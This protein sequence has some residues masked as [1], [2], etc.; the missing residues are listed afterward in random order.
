MSHDALVVQS[1]VPRWGAYERVTGAAKYTADIKPTGMLIGK[2]LTS[3]YPHARI[4]KVDKSK[5]EA[6]PGVEG[7]IA[8]EDIPKKT[9]IPSKH[10]LTL[11]PHYHPEEEIRDMYVLTDKARFVGDKI[12]AVAAVDEATA[13]KALELIEVEYEVLEAVFDPMEAMRPGSPV[14][15]DFAKNNIPLRMHFPGSQ[16]DVE[17]GFQEADC[18]IED[19]FHSSKQQISQMEPSACVASFG[20]DGRLTIWSPNQSV[21]LHRTKIAELFDMPEGM[22]R[23]ITPH[24]GGSFGKHGSLH[25]EPVCIALAKKTGKPVKVEYSREEDFFGTETRQTFITQAKIG[26]KK[27]GAIVALEEKLISDG[28]AYFSRSRVTSLVNIGAFTG[29]YRCAN[30]SADLECVYTNTPTT[31]GIRGYGNSEATSV[32]EQ[33]VDRAAAEIG[34]DP[35]ELRLKNVK[36]AGDLSNSGLPMRACSLEELIRLGAEKVGWREKRARDKQNGCKR[37]GIGMAIM[38]DVSGAY[39]SNIQSRNAYL[40]FNEDGSINLMVSAYDM[41]QN[42][43]GT[44][45]QIAAEA[46]GIRYEDVHMV[47]GDTDTTMFD[48]GVQA[49]AGLYQMG[50]AVLDA[51]QQAKKRLLERAAKKMGSVAEELDIR[52][53]R[54]YLK[55]N[56]SIGIS[57]GEVT[58]Q[59]TYNFEGDNEN[60]SAKGTFSPSDNPPPFAAVFAE[61]EVDTQTG[62]VEVMKILYVNDSGTPINP[63]TVEGQIEGGVGQAIGYTLTESYVVNRKTGRLETDN[64][65]T[66]MIPSALDMPEIEMVLYQDPVASGPFGAKA[67]GHSTTIAVNPAI[68][69]A[70]YDA[71]GVSITDMPATAEKILEA[72]NVR[73]PASAEIASVTAG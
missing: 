49:S 5:A 1:R 62:D 29:L 12:A 22:I 27:N 68:A 57:V 53:R 52:D 10:H 31:G 35:V 25:A 16:G 6:L 18:V 2:I 59:A 41:G 51:A 8:F 38:M 33:L 72:M 58:R 15:H 23:W 48:T 50:N 9:F 63:A 56:P 73:G 60:I 40:K 32:L 44:C 13:E 64:F 54:I 69:N 30:T 55:S 24:V 21:F 46:L 43:A 36:R 14:V 4:A 47:T 19:T 42:L 66:Y 67:V 34:M 37:Y 61:V 3:P 65:N 11:R 28:G 71:V 39:P 20:P 26:V 17:K 70:I 7:V 45:A